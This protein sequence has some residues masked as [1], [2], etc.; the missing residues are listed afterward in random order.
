MSIK[1]NKK[2]YCK[3]KQHNFALFNKQ[4]NIYTSMNL[5]NAKGIRFWKKILLFTT[6]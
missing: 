3:I 6:K 5:I 1:I 2:N 4:F